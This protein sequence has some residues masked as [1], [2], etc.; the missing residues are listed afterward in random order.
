MN[1]DGICDGTVDDGD[2]GAGEFA[3]CGRSPELARDRGGAGGRNPDRAARERG[4]IV[5]RL[6]QVALVTPVLA[7][8]VAEVR[9]ALDLGE[10][11]P[12]PGVALFGLENAVLPVGDTFLEILAPLRD[13]C[14]GARHLARRGGA[15][16]YMAIVQTDDLAAARRRVD[17]AGVRV[18]FEHALDDIATLHL[19]PHDT[20]GTLLSIDA[21][22]PAESWRWAGP[23]WR[24][25]SRSG[26]VDRI[27][28]VEIECDD[29][30]TVAARW[31]A[32][33]GSPSVPGAA[34]EHEIR[35]DDSVL[36]FVPPRDTRGEG[37]HTIVLRARPDVPAALRQPLELCGTRFV[38]ADG[39]T[40]RR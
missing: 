13:D 30:P 23:G 33:L 6:R 3:A 18:V 22:V 17:A 9:R 40:P 27:V 11:F 38:F 37:I 25:R 32:L 28:G 4:G 31:A 1:R 21:A 34:R 19:H 8:A 12:D 7:P 14:A 35:L 24:E 26:R 10:P 16:G 39:A 29:P 36:R 2:V 15:G 5:T 20:G